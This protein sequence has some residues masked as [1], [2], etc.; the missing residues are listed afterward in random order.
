DQARRLSDPRT[1]AGTCSALADA[2]RPRP[3][4]PLPAT[5]CGRASGARPVATALSGWY[6]EQD[7]GR[8]TVANLLTPDKARRMA[9]NFAKLPEL[10]RRLSATGA[11]RAAA[12]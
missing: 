11:F 10:L 7:P 2:Q 3:G 4:R 5:R 9:V 8:R 12:L 1:P 6:H